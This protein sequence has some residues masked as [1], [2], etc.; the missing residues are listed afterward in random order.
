MSLRE[1]AAGETVKEKREGG[2]DFMFL[3]LLCF[4]LTKNS[5]ATAAPPVHRPPP[6][7][8]D[9]VRGRGWDCAP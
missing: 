7:Q 3:F 8:R 2:R 5:H 9:Q 6:V 4:V 1:M